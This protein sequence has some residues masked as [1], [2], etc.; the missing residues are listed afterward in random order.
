MPDRLISSDSPNAPSHA[1]KD[2]TIKLNKNRFFITINEKIEIRI[3]SNLSNSTIKCFWS[4]KFKKQQK[5]TKNKQ[6]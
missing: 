5:I 2:K 1:P 3:N 6:M 4:E